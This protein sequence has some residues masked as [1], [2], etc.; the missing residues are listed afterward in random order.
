MK[1]ITN[2]P[3]SI[4][5]RLQ[6]FARAN[7]KPFQEI[8]QYYGMERFLYRLSKTKY[9]SNFILKGGL[10]FYTWG[11]SQRRMTRDIDL[12]AFIK[13]DKETILTVIQS[14]FEIPAIEDGL[15]FDGHDIVIEDSML[16]ADYL[17]ARIHFSAH[18]GK[19]RIPIQVDIGYSDIITSDVRIEK[20]PTILAGMESPVIKTYPI[21]TI[22]SE[23]FHAMVLLGEINSRWKDFYDIWLLSEIYDIDGSLLQNAI[24]A[25][26]LQRKTPIPAVIPAAFSEKFISDNQQ[27]WYSFVT[28][29]KL[30][31][32]RVEDLHGVIG[33][34]QTFLIPPVQS[35]LHSEVF[36]KHWL[37]GIGWE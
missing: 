27:N 14:A 10:V 15:V 37:S 6:N 34:L 28:R 19:A 3:A 8:L 36:M 20:Y 7:N 22:I 17:G 4:N 26:F 2:F 32:D 11:V 9:S 12:R 30:T 24:N 29:N 23:K 21:E 13:N 5:A 35:A 18:L 16:D 25:T 33:R 31:I 1:Q